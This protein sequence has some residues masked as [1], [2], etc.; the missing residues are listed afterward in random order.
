M[1]HP[2]V[3]SLSEYVMPEATYHRKRYQTRRS[4]RRDEASI[5]HRECVHKIAESGEG[6][7]C[8]ETVAVKQSD[9]SAST[10][11]QASVR[12]RVSFNYKQSRHCFHSYLKL[13]RVFCYKCGLED[14]RM[15]D[16]MKCVK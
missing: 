15:A 8:S 1:M 9:W 14:K 5:S 16:C 4:A 6:M 10:Q 7:E 13:L 12:E 11:A 2:S 3:V